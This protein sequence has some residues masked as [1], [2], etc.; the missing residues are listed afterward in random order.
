M[1]RM[2]YSRLEIE[3]R[4]QREA[5][6]ALVSKIATAPASGLLGQGGASGTRTSPAKASSKRAQQQCP[7][8]PAMVR[9]DHLESHVRRVHRQASAHLKAGVSDATGGTLR[10]KAGRYD[11]TPHERASVL[12]ALGPTSFPVRLSQAEAKAL[13]QICRERQVTPSTLVGQIVTRWLRGQI[14]QSE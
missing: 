10:P 3:R 12:Q 4:D 13:D 5:R 7:H 6:R 2:R 9:V 8:C 1:T 14:R 11:A